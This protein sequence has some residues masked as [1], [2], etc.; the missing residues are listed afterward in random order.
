MLCSDLFL[1]ER[2][3]VSQ[4]QSSEIQEALRTIANSWLHVAADKGVASVQEMADYG[5]AAK[6]IS[7]HDLGGSVLEPKQVGGFKRLPK[8]AQDFVRWIGKVHL[9]LAFA[10]RGYGHLSNAAAWYQSGSP[11]RQPEIIVVL[12]KREFDLIRQALTAGTLSSFVAWRILDDH[13]SQLVHEL[14]HAYEDYISAGRF[15][16]NPKSRKARLARQVLGH[17]DPK[18]HALYMNDPVEISA[19]LAQVFAQEERARREQDW[20]AYLRAVRWGFRG[21]KDLPDSVK[22]RLTLRIAREWQRDRKSAPDTQEAAKRLQD[23]LQAAGATIRLHAPNDARYISVEGLDEKDPARIAAVL[24]PVLAFADHY[25]LTV[26]LGDK[27]PIPAVR[28]LGFKNQ[29]PRSVNGGKRDYSL[30]LGTVYLRR[31]VDRRAA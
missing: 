11:G 31:P 26:A 8:A 14:R 20:P 18:R 24:R 28:P 5:Y 29:R 9:R 23:R 2:S 15:R 16:D 3:A 7:Q 13:R 19:R 4:D 30:P 21:W 12:P 10:E 27:L 25:G 17:D 22:R 6:D 1:L